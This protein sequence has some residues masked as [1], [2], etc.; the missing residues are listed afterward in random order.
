[1]PAPPPRSARDRRHPRVHHL[2]GLRGRLAEQRDRPRPNRRFL[3]EAASP[4][5]V[6]GHRGLGGATRSLRPMTQF[7]HDRLLDAFT[8]ALAAALGQPPEAIRAQVKPAEPEHG[9]LAFPPFPLAKQLR[10]APPAIA[11]DLAGKLSVPG[12]Q[13]A[14]AG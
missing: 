13:I 7:L 8:T 9:D 11:A 1:R 10:K 2:R 6:A 5:E 12:L 14:A 4:A 3:R